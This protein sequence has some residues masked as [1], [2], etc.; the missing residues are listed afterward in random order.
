MKN[1]IM[2]TIHG[3]ADSAE[4]FAPLVS[5]LP[6][7]K[8]VCINL[9]TN[10]N[11]E[12]I[13]T[14]KE[15]ASYCKNYLKKKGILKYSL[16]GF[17]MGGIVALEIAHNNKNIQNLYLLNSFPAL[18]ANK[19]LRN[20]YKKIKRD[21]MEGKNVKTISKVNKK[22]YTQ[23]GTLMNC[24]DQDYI[25]IYKQIKVPKKL[26]LYRDDTIL[27]YQECLKSAKLNKLDIITIDR[28][29]HNKKKC[30]WDNL[31]KSVE[32]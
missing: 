27:S 13:Y 8:F 7:K 18:I 23:M 5:L 12:K 24:L 14:I 32:F 1:E 3:Y 25:D 28:G 4:M 31:I 21:L 20:F 19:E 30:Y 16:I 26:I 11:K 9:P 15:L 6:E 10:G 22:N 29:G 2:V 17:S